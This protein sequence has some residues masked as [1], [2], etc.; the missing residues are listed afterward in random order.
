MQPVKRSQPSKAQSKGKRKP[1]LLFGIAV[2]ATIGWSSFIAFVLPL[3]LPEL[4][5]V[6]A[7]VAENLSPLAISQ[8]DRPNYKT[9]DLEQA[10]VHVVTIPAATRLS[11]AVADELTTVEAFAQQENALVVLNGGF[12]D[13]Q[14][15]KTTSHLIRQ[16]QNVGDPAENERLV[17]NP[18][19]SQYMDQILNRS[20]FRRYEC[21]T[22]G[23]TVD[24]QYDITLH[25]APVP[26]GCSLYSALGAGPQLLP[27]DTSLAEGFTDYAN[28]E[29]VRDA[30]GS[31]GANARS[32]I[33]LTSD[34]T[35]LLIMVA[36]RS[37]APG[38]TLLEVSEFATSLGTVKLLNL[39]GGS[40]S[41]LYYDG[42]TYL[43]RLDAEGNPIERPVKSVVVVEQ[44]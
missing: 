30:I 42:Q 9:Y 12:F 17:D 39:D 41:S 43:A 18:N 29:L 3:F 35:I 38:L 11:I 44:D 6:S 22:M 5:P 37:D 24:P 2:A 27:K 1:Y 31:R 10:T 23:R 26:D 20:E 40:S 8:S 34:K 28:G 7:E 19:L 4:P 32:A 15:G 33:A 36:Q 13:P 25:D 16:G 21:Q 14:N